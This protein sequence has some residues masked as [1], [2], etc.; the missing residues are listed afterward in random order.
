MRHFLLSLPLLALATLAHAESP[1]VIS[2]E[3]AQLI[4]ELGMQA[5]VKPVRDYAGWR[6]LARIVV[7]GSLRDA[8][9][10]LA[11][12]APGVEIVVANSAAEALSAAPRADALL[13]FC[14][15]ELLAA[16]T[17]VRW[18]QTFYA[19]VEACVTLPQLA[20]RGIIVTNMQRVMGPAMSEHGIA[21]LL[22]LSRHL[23]TYI[24]RGTEGRWDRSSAPGAPV[25]VVAGKT[26]LVVGLG[27]IGTE[28][29][30]RAHAL[31]MR[32]IATRASGRPGPDFVEHVGKPGDLHALAARAD[33][34]ISA[35]PLTDET[36]RMFDAAFF[37]AL[38]PGAYF[39]N[40]GRGQSVITEDL[41]AALESGRLAGA[42]LDVTDPEPLP[43]DHPLWRMPRVIITPHMA[44][45]SDTEAGTRA[46]VVR[47]NLRR[48][49]AGEPLLSVVDIERGY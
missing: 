28:V 31:G 47:E 13:G 35:L 21:M 46:M 32:V 23:D 37:A 33:A 25:Q 16:A 41:L 22:A 10:Y 4:A 17:K 11:P 9:T 40:L 3:A 24:V 12:V 14:D 39:I 30:R 26:L 19:G 48:W 1:P 6:P 44:A 7:H 42:G 29:A 2:P 34:V 45:S 15:A 5:D 49:Q 38:K 27:G 43:A 20:D 18:V 36:R 8:A